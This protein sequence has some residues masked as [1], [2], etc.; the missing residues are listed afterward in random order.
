MNSAIHPAVSESTA[1][2]VIALKIPRDQIRHK[3]GPAIQE[4]TETLAAQ[5]VTPSGPL[6]SLHF[7]ADEEQF[8]FEVG[9]PVSSAIQPV[10]RVRNSQ[11]PAS[12][13]LRTIYTGPYEGLGDAWGDFMRVVKGK[14]VEKKPG[15]WERYLTG[16][17]TNPDPASWQTELNVPLASA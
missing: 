5:K 7:D 11:F 17:S 9:F 1:T 15:F 6:F 10:G 12:P 14:S 13:V 16:P 3:M 2:A 4:V 8:D